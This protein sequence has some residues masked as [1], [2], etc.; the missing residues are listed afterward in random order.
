M[1][2]FLRRRG[3]ALG[4]GTVLVAAAVPV[5][6]YSLAMVER[7]ALAAT[8]PAKTT[9]D[10]LVEAYARH[11]AATWDNF[12]PRDVWN[13]LRKFPPPFRPAKTAVSFLSNGGL[14]SE[15][16][17][18]ARFMLGGDFKVIRHDLVFR[19][20][21]HSAVT[22]LLPDGRPVFIDP[23]LGVIF[24]DGDRLLSLSQVREKLSAG[25]Q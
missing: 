22:V 7:S 24:K 16:V 25:T 11:A 21:G 9:P 14:C 8:L 15:F 1:L 10:A 6:I 18:A 4:L 2:A 13:K 3:R 20:A 5:S 19:N 17:F 12:E 23:F